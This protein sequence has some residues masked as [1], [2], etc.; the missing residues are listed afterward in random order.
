MASEIS[1]NWKLKNNKQAAWSNKM[2][3][4]PIMSSPT[5]KVNFDSDICQLQ[6]MKSGTLN[7]KLDIPGEF[8]ENHLIMMF[9]L[10][11]NKKVFIGPTLCLYVKIIPAVEIS[12]FDERQF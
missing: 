12:S 10:R 8:A 9:K 7:V 11:T 5:V 1:V 2:Q 3:L 6:G 4:I